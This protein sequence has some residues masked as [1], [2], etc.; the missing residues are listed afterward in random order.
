MPAPLAAGAID[1]TSDGEFS[2]SPSPAAPTPPTLEPAERSAKP[3]KRAREDDEDADANGAAESCASH[4]SSSPPKRVKV[5]K[6]QFEPGTLDNWRWAE[7]SLERSTR[8]PTPGA[9][10]VISKSAEAVWPTDLAPATSEAIEE[11][12]DS[13]H[14]LC[15]PGSPPPELKDVATPRGSPSP[16][17][18]IRALPRAQREALLAARKVAPVVKEDDGC[19][20]DDEST[21]D[22]RSAETIRGFPHPH[23]RG[24]FTR[25]PPPTEAKSL[26]STVSLGPQATLPT[27]AQIG[28]YETLL[29]EGLDE[30]MKFALNQLLIWRTHKAWESG[31]ASGIHTQLSQ[32]ALAAAK[33]SAIESK[34]SVKVVK[35]RKVLR[36]SYAMYDY[37]EYD[38]SPS[39]KWVKGPDL[40][41]E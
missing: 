15:D 36:H 2:R 4:A 32:H 14:A 27:A 13:A 39:A 28:E 6:V 22:R 40:D 33:A 10:S 16:E 34:G 41:D 12:E 38:L 18:R 25:P 23:P 20:S 1:L 26:D 31:F 19:E 21:F 5:S 29:R 30:G 7:R 8:P 35:P 9:P 17:E 11:A 37:E 24:R 3:A